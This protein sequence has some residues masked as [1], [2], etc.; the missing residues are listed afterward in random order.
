MPAGAQGWE[1][2]GLRQAFRTPSRTRQRAH[3]PRLGKPGACAEGAREAGYPL[4]PM[5]AGRGR[6]VALGSVPAPRGRGL[7]GHPGMTP[8]T[9]RATRDRGPGRAAPLA[10]RR[11]ERLRGA[12][13]HGRRS[14]GGPGRG[15]PGGVRSPASAVAWSSCLGVWHTAPVTPG[16]EH[17]L[18]M[19]PAC[20][21]PR[22]PPPRRCAGPGQQGRQTGSHPT[23]VVSCPCGP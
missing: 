10:A 18:I 5:Q 22:A 14:G 8:G 9:S 23:G 19:L 13:S 17:P 7:G 2:C 4:V 20:G 11:A 21:A 16:D 1:A 15:G 6:R 3:V 12:V